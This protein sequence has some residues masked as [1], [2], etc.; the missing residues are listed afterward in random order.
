MLKLNVCSIFSEDFSSEVGFKLSEFSL[1]LIDPDLDICKNLN[2]FLIKQKDSLETIKVTHRVDAETFKIILSMPHLKHLSLPAHPPSEN[3]A[4]GFSSQS[5]L[6]LELYNFVN[7]SV[8]D[9]TVFLQAFPKVEI[10]QVYG[11]STELANAISANCNSLKRLYIQE[12]FA[13]IISKIEFFS[14][15][16]VFLC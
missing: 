6:S 9:Y 4:N 7:W 3:T 8:N 5:I 11:I 1:K 16:E 15:I 2:Q 14:N 13:R 10:L 12:Q